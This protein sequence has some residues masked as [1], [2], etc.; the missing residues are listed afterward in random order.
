MP[1]LKQACLA[2]TANLVAGVKTPRHAAGRSSPA[3]H[4]VRSASPVALLC[5]RENV[6]DSIAAG[7]ARHEFRI[8]RFQPLV[9][10]DVVTLADNAHEVE[11]VEQVFD[12]VHHS[13]FR[14]APGLPEMP[15]FQ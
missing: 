15:A 14:P 1:G 4:G 11:V 2:A 10:H 8:T 7:T 3:E 12:V 5:A 6:G 13:S 9:T